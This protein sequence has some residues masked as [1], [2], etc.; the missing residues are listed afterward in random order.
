MPTFKAVVFSHYSRADKTYNVRIRVTHKRKSRYIDTGLIAVASDLTK[1]LKIKN[2][3]FIDETNNIISG[4]RSK[5]NKAA[6]KV[7]VMDVDQVVEYLKGP[8]TEALDFLKFGTDYVEGLKRD[9]RTG[10]A[11]SH[12]AAINALKRYVVS[13]SFDVSMITVSFLKDFERWI[14]EN[15]LKQTNNYKPEMSRAP[16]HYMES[17]RAIHNEMKREYNDED[18][19]IIRI[20]FSPFSKYKIPGRV[21]TKKRALPVEVI[22]K[23]YKLKYREVSKRDITN[24]FNL[25]KDCFILSFCLIGMNSADLYHC[26]DLNDGKLTYKRKK[27][28][29]RRKDEAE[30]CVWIPKEAEVLLKKYRNTTGTRVFNFHQ[31]Y[32]NES[33]F[34]KALNKGLKSIGKELGIEDLEFYAARHS[35]ATIALNK[36]GIDE[37]TVHAALNHVDEEMKVTEIYLEK[38]WSIINNA[39]RKVLDLVLK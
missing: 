22:R 12:Q 27:T 14:R 4:Y 17:L 9:G 38:D 6:D 29:T 8:T 33:N 1:K 11:G 2:E 26:T 24:R 36:A 21:L 32:A 25:A 37:Y 3:S 7:L 30:M 19:G 31:L 13:D 39:N 23:I 34:N 18:A 16:S 28:R 15:P 35:W 10:T 20:P 5:I